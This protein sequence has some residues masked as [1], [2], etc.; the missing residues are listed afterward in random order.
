MEN[1]DEDEKYLAHQ[2]MP[3]WRQENIFNAMVYGIEGTP[4]FG[5]KP[6][7]NLKLIEA[8]VYI[9]LRVYSLKGGRK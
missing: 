1:E 5:R 6:S 2:A 4:L 7:Y 9:Y 8:F 3:L